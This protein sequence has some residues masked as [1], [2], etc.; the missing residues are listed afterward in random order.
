MC[1]RYEYARECQTSYTLRNKIIQ[2]LKS[3]KKAITPETWIKLLA[4]DELRLGR[5]R[6]FFPL[7]YTKIPAGVREQAPKHKP[8]DLV[9]K[10]TRSEIYGGE[11][12]ESL[13]CN[14]ND[15][16]ADSALLQFLS[17]L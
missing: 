16:P 1:I 5:L 4:T 14:R 9:E 8:E 12:M 6:Y 11:W 15:A 2:K 7:P 13:Q 17:F 3:P 10:L